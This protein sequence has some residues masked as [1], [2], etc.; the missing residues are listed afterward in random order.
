MITVFNTSS[1]LVGAKPVAPVLAQEPTSGY[2][3]RIGFV[4]AL[5]E[6]GMR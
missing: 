3:S 1:F 6:G 4:R 5:L 2:G